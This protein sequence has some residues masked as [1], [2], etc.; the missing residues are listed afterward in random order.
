MSEI[1]EVA[2]KPE[3]YCFNPNS[4]FTR[5]RKLSMETVLTGIIGMGS[6]SLTNELID[7]FHSSP[8]MRRLYPFCPFL[9]GKYDSGSSGFVAI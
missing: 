8:E 1:K 2:N 3:L 5:K 4:D 7:L 6:G 9:P